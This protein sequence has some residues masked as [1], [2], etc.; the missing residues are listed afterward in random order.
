[1]KPNK[2][3]Y[4]RPAR[5]IWMLITLVGL[6]AA[7]APAANVEDILE[8]VSSSHTRWQ[9]LQGTAVVVWTGPSG[10]QQTYEEEFCNS[11]ACLGPLCVSAGRRSASV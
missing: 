10:A 6:L 5:A 9:T 2:G 7:C 4:N 11:T 3:G 8:L 1:M